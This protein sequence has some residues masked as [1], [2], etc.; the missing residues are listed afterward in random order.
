[1]NHMHRI[2][3]EFH[4]LA[5]NRL[6]TVGGKTR[7]QPEE[8]GIHLRPVLDAPPPSDDRS[9]RLNQ[10]WSIARRF[11][12][13]MNWHDMNIKLR[14]LPQPVYRFEIQDNKSS[15]IDGALFA[16][17]HNEIDDPE[18]LLLIEAHREEAEL[19][20]LYTPLRFTNREVWVLDRGNEVWRVGA[21]TTGIFDGV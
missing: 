14:F 3:H 5:P 12:A 13:G 19:R 18:A 2:F 9:R 4:S 11:E 21:D 17:S 20:W 10:M 7:W 15:V 6:Y 16:Y 8:P 1:Q